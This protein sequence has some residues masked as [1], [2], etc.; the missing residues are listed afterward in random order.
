MQR[1]PSLQLIARPIQN[2]VCSSYYKGIV[3]GGNV[4]QQWNR[5]EYSNLEMSIVMKSRSHLFVGKV[6]LF[7]R[8]VADFDSVWPHEDSEIW[9]ALEIP[10]ALHTK[11]HPSAQS[12][13]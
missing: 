6:Y 12:H 3:H 1:S 5:A 13:T 2:N 8:E 7:D 11:T 9:L 10:L 4:A